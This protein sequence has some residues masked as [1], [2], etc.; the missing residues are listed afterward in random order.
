[1]KKWGLL[2]LLIFLSAWAGIYLWI[3]G[4]LD[5][6]VAGMVNC[7]ENGA[8]RRLTEETCW[9]KWWPQA[10]PVNQPYCG[11]DRHPFIYESYSY[12]LTGVFSKG[13]EVAIQ[14]GDFSFDTR[15]LILP[16]ANPDTIFLE[17]RGH[18]AG[19]SLN[20]FER[21]RQYRRVK[22]IREG[23]AGILASLCSFLEKKENIYGFGIRELR[24]ADNTKLLMAEVCGG[25]WTVSQA[26][27]QLQLFIKDYRMESVAPSFETLVTDRSKEPDTT[28]WVTRIY[29][30]VL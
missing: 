6:S 17:W 12:R 9:E 4:E 2:L 26:I 13:I 8:Y 11:T 28:K 23:M 30:P 16:R 3:P 27:G 21:I 19:N 15:I 1:M 29:F 7:T 20:P 24:S 25:D 18:L 22:V 5:L 10:K 14:Q